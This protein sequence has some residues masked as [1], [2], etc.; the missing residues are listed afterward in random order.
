VKGESARTIAAGELGRAYGEDTRPGRFFSVHGRGAAICQAFAKQFDAVIDVLHV[1]ELNIVGEEAG[2]PRTALIRQLSEVARQGLR[3][4]IEILW[5]GEIMATVAIR[6][7]RPADVTVQEAR[8]RN[9]DLVIVGGH[10]KTGRLRMWRRNTVA[11][12]IR[13]ARCPVLVVPIANG[14]VGRPD[15]LK[16]NI[17]LN[18]IH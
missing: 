2:V 4:L 15:D 5:A 10:E 7:G 3:K 1:V 13:R 9:S 8:A 18:Q 16:L 6:E 14:R 12:V 17:T 11:R